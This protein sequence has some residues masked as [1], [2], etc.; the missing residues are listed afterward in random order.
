M[1][2]FEELFAELEQR[3][4]SPSPGSASTGYLQAGPH[5]IGKKLLEE[6]GELWL[7]LEHESPQR[8]AE[9]AGQ[10]IYFIQLALVARGVSIVELERSL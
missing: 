1:K 6:A 7:A 10:L 9:E 8:V 2:K 5:E 3:S 4:N